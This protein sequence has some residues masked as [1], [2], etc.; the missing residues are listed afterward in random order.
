MGVMNAMEKTIKILYV[1]GYLGSGNGHSSELIRHE[2]VSRGMQ[3]IL[4]APD[5][6]VTKPGETKRM[7]QNLIEKNGY[8]YI[9]ASSLGAFYSMQVP[10]TIKILVN[11]ALPDNLKLIR[12]LDPKHNPELTAE[13]F[14]EINREKDYFF[15]EVFNEDYRQQSYVIYGIRDSIAPNEG[16][17]KQYYNDGSK[18]WHIDMEHKLDETGANKIF[19]LISGTV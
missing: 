3:H 15:S 12:D 14:S 18:I 7:I 6:P 17:L 4:D 16:F 11:I 13:F 8:N 1:H 19:E 9:V 10:G 5:F 2:F